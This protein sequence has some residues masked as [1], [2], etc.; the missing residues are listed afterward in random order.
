VYPSEGV[1]FGMVGH[2]KKLT[3]DELRVLGNVKSCRLVNSYGCSVGVPCHHLQ[4]QTVLE[5]SPWNA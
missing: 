5:D 3:G 1:G 4:G 2:I